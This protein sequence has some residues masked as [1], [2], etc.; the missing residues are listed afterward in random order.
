MEPNNPNTAGGPSP[1]SAG[2]VLPTPEV[3]P[4][5]PVEHGQEKAPAAPEKERPAGESAA[6]SAPISMP[7]PVPQIVV[8]NSTDDDDQK[9]ATK[10][11]IDAPDLADDVDVI[12]KEWVDKAKQIVERN[13]ENPSQQNHEVALLKADYLKKRYGKEIKVPEDNTKKA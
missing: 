2:P 3:Q 11:E 13:K 8:Q 7:Q 12:E 5:V 9:S 4:G 1:E 10:I 6:Q